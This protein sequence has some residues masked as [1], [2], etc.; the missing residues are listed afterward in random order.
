MGDLFNERHLFLVILDKVHH[1]YDQVVSPAQQ[2][3]AVNRL[4]KELESEIPRTYLHIPDLLDF[5][6]DD[7]KITFKWWPQRLVE[8]TVLDVNINTRIPWKQK[9]DPT[10][11]HEHSY[12]LRVFVGFDAMRITDSIAGKEGSLYVYSRQSGRLISHH[13]DARTLLNLSAGGTMFCQGLTVIIDDAGGNLPLSP[14]K[15]EVSFGEENHGEIHKE[16]LMAWVGGAVHFYYSHH[17]HKC[18]AKKTVLTRKVARFGGDV[19]L[20]NRQLKILSSSSLTTYDV[21][22]KSIGK[23]IRVDKSSAREIVGADT[24]YRIAPKRNSTTSAPK[25]VENGMKRK[26]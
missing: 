22:F 14:T 11:E 9:F 7:K 10:N 16:N 12:R 15:Q 8:L 17:L 3:I 26:I 21:S 4:M 25:S 2:K 1:N 13:P 24:L 19:L 18:E 20:K 5:K 6:I 23:T